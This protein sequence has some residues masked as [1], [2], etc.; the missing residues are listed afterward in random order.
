MVKQS[1]ISHFTFRYLHAQLVLGTVG[2][3]TRHQQN[4]ISH[5]HYV[6]LFRLITPFH[7][8]AFLAVWISSATAQYHHSVTTTEHSR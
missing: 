5:L 7:Q 6:S 8:H 3:F 2:I 1:F 4:N